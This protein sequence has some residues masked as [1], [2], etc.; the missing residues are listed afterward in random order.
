MK[1]I[2]IL[3]VL[4]LLCFFAASCTE[5]IHRD[6]I[7]PS[8]SSYTFDADGETFALEITAVGESGGEWEYSGGD[9][10]WLTIERTETGLN[11]TASANETL[12]FRETTITLTY[13]IASADV[14]I[15][16]LSSKF[17]G[18]FVELS[19]NDYGDN[20]VFSINSKF[21]A[22]CPTFEKDN[23]VFPP[24]SACLQDM[25]TL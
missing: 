15:S 8:V 5:E 22:G 12:E 24:K 9:D 7:Y 16:Q 13:G 17:D 23:E 4:T 2:N 11:L 18:S 10:S 14:K 20:I 6:Q 1:K 21:A 25:K 3:S 19:M